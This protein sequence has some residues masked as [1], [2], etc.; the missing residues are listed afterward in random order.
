[1]KHS[2]M[3]HFLGVVVG[4]PVGIE[5]GDYVDLDRYYH[6]LFYK[7]VSPR[8]D[9]KTILKCILKQYGNG[10]DEI[11][12]RADG[13]YVRMNVLPNSISIID[14]VRKVYDPEVCMLSKG[15]K[16]LDQRWWRSYYGNRKRRLI[17]S[18]KYKRRFKEY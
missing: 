10:K 17:Y 5:E 11:A 18:Q 13:V 7:V 15:S 2:F 12:E 9:K 6:D 3:V 8:K 16:L 4:Y 1:M 14:E